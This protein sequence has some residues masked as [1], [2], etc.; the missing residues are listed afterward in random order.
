M[1]CEN[2]VSMWLISHSSVDKKNPPFFILFLFCG[3]SQHCEVIIIVISLGFGVR[4]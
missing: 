3:V 2:S 4:L 1:Q